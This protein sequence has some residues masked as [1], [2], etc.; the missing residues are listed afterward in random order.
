MSSQVPEEF[1]CPISGNLM[2]NPVT[3]KCGHTFDKSS[4]EEWKQRSDTCPNCRE[5]ITD[6]FTVNYT[7][8]SLIDKSSGGHSV[9]R[10]NST[11]LDIFR[12]SVNI[13]EIGKESLKEIRA[14]FG[15][16][17]DY[18]DL[19]LEMPEMK[20]RRPV[21]FV[22]IIDVSGS[23]GSTVGAGEGGRAFTR[24]D[25]V[26]HVLNVLITTLTEAD[27]LSLIT[28]SNEAEVILDLVP[29]SKRNKI[30]AKNCVNAFEPQANTYTGPA[31]R[32]AY[33][34]M[35]TAPTTNV[36]SI[37]LLTDGQ[38]T[39]GEEVL[40]KIFDQI[41]KPSQVQLNTFGFSNDIWS[42]SLQTL[43]IK[44]GG[45][46]GFIPDQSMIGTIFVNFMA[47]TFMTFAQDVYVEPNHNY[48]LNHHDNAKTNLQY[49]RKRH[50]L[51]RQLHENHGAVFTFRIGYSKSDMIEIKAMPKDD[52]QEY[53]VQKAKYKLLDMVMSPELPHVDVPSFA[54]SKE[55]KHV[56]DFLHEIKQAKKPDPNFEQIK[57]SL[58][59]WGSWGA[60]YVR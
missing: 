17:G 3:L 28:F 45:I 9:S 54:E 50:F 27:S 5:L 47:N 40:Q 26:K 55:L 38:D 4:I 29:M 8:K 25:L 21:S 2:R 22:C 43:A 52:E 51:L 39:A 13:E 46:F 35:R 59:Y 16:H 56:E 37:V 42:K 15:R 60:H 7:L 6:S 57:L 58:Q 14:T 1:L 48:E 19:C 23:M 34:I 18:V 49:D 10:P 32:K 36:R 33:D 24:L 20:K 53:V 12:N 11:Q 44:G 30:L 41:E 31:L